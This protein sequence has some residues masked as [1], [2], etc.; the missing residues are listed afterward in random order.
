MHSPSV[1]VPPIALVLGL[2]V[3]TSIATIQIGA[4]PGV[5]GNLAWISGD[6]ACTAVRFAGCDHTFT[7]NNGHSYTWKGCGG[8]T[9]LLNGDGS[10]NSACHFNPNNNEQCGIRRSF[11]C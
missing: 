2:L 7:L 11:S 1:A 9:F 5:D 8:D 6:S 10:F 4:T 3:R